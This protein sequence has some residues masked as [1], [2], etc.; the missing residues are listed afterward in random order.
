MLASKYHALVRKNRDYYIVFEPFSKSSICKD[1]T[2]FVV[3]ANQL[4]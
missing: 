4:Y 3:A 1:D 2:F